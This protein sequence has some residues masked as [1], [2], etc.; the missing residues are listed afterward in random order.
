MFSHFDTVH[1]C[2]RQTDRHADDGNSH[3]MKANLKRTAGLE[4]L[5]QLAR[6]QI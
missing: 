3:K 2:D 1:A 5:M 6:R 4:E